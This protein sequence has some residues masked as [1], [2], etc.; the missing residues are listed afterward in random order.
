MMV[1]EYELMK[2]SD[3][4]RKACTVSAIER[5]FLGCILCGDN[6]VTQY[7]EID[8][9]T[10]SSRLHANS[11]HEVRLREM[12]WKSFLR[13][14]FVFAFDRLIKWID[15]YRKLQGVDKNSALR[16]LLVLKKT[17]RELR[18]YLM[19]DE[20]YVVADKGKKTNRYFTSDGGCVSDPS[21][22][23]YSHGFNSEGRHI[24]KLLL[25]NRL[26]FFSAFSLLNKTY[27]EAKK[28]GFFDIFGATSHD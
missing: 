13:D 16:E 22:S 15:E 2:M 3:E 12:A 11:N 27:S 24:R 1:S 26:E 7:D 18:D 10:D 25:G 6:I 14:S 19:H 8:A 28:E 23:V 21:S 20:E 9:Q 17:M 4:D 5:L